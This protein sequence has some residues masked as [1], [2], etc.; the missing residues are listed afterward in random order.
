M[1]NTYVGQM[2]LGPRL[3]GNQDT[4]CNWPRDLGTTGLTT[5]E[6]EEVAGSQK[7]QSILIVEGARGERAPTFGQRG[8]AETLILDL[9]PW[10]PRLLPHQIQEAVLRLP[11]LKLCSP[12]Q[13][14]GY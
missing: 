4:Y 5:L 8:R 10:E 3:K 2:I 13:S 9:L 7:S 11:T 6:V 14:W 12:S 1:V